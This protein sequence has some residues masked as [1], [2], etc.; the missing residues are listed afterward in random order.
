MKRADWHLHGAL[1]VLLCVA[2]ATSFLLAGGLLLLWRLP[3]ISADTRAALIADAHEVA[4]RAEEQLRAQNIQLELLARMLIESPAGLPDAVLSQAV[5]RGGFSAVY[6]VSA[7]GRVGQAAVSS[8]LGVARARELVGNDLSA[9]PL[10]LRL[11][12]EARLSWSDKYVSPVSNRVA[13]GIGVP[14]GDAVLIGE[15]ALAG[16]ARWA[17]VSGSGKQLWIADSRGE[18]LAD[19]EDAERVGVFSLA[20]QPLFVRVLQQGGPQVGH[21]SLEKQDF[22]AAVVRS[23][24][25]NWY[26]VAR[27]AGGW[28]NPRA[29]T[30][31]EYAFLGLGFSLGLALLLAPW[32]A[33]QMARPIC[34][35]S[36]R[37]GAV[38]RGDK[39]QP[40]PRSGIAEIDELSNRLAAMDEAI[41]AREHELREL[42]AGLELRVQQRT[43]ELAGANAELSGSLLRLHQAQDELVRAEKLAALGAMVA[44]L[45]HELNTPVGNSLMATSTL[46][47]ALL[48]FRE[49]VTRG[50]RRSELN[51]FLAAA[52]TGTDIALRNLQRAAE[53]VSSFKQVAADQASSQHRAFMLDEMVAEVA[54]TVR[55]LL[56]K[57]GVV[58]EIDVPAQIRM[59]SYPGPLGQVLTNLLVNT[60]MHA[61]AGREGGLVV[62]SALPAEA[63]R[64]CIEVRDDGVGIAAELLPRIFD[65]FVTTRLGSGGTGLGLHIVHNIVVQVLGGSVGVQSTPGEGTVFVLE[66]PTTVQASPQADMP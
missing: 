47:D 64:V 46:R 34:Q 52:D 12:R 36:A 6:L 30:A 7:D 32:W 53:L 45:A 44:G 23:S 31:F 51:E 19:S 41:R 65:P 4:M 56:R 21:M 48:A 26:F 17:E 63:G 22:D 20:N 15:V 61:F 5:T 40:W 62:V 33:T 60:T 58:L 49:C 10:F 25:L 50:V 54:L 59:E 3:Q 16:I 39:V 13:V 66:L 27:S 35:I 24:L 29:R 42:N 28:R 1:I 9:S 43:E 38:A 37:A 57:H 55:P 2:S 11:R 8:T 14:A 18:L